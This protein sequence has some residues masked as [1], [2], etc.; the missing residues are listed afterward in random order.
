[1][2]FV[3]GLIGLVVSLAAA[4]GMGALTLLGLNWAFDLGLEITYKTAAGVGI[5]ILC[6]FIFLAYLQE[7]GRQ[8]S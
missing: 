2:G 6:A 4:G 7:F 5:L 3:Y 1:M 8:G